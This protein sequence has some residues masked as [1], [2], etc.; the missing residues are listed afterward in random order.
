MNEIMKKTYEL[1][2]VLEDSELVRDIGMY[3]ERIMNDSDLSSL[4]QKGNSLS[5]EYAL[6][7]IKRKLYKN[8]DYKRYMD[9][10][11]ELMYIVM[12][13]NYRYSKIL[14]KGSCYR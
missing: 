4:I 11:N 2:D 9:K 8:S 6:L 5:D 10:Y 3:R 12:D 7:D 13:I 1:I 14:G